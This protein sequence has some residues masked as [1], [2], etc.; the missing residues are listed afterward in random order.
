M[1]GV[2][3]AHKR[4]CWL[5]QA[6]KLATVEH[7][8]ENGHRKDFKQT[9]ELSTHSYFHSQIYKGALELWCP[10]VHIKVPHSF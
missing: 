5:E 8:V 7:I 10:L 3:L 4:Y 1:A 2:Y 9:Q 6:E